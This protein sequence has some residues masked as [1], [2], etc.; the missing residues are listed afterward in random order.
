MNFYSLDNTS[1]CQP[2]VLSNAQNMI[3]LSYHGETTVN[4]VQWFMYSTE[5]TLAEFDDPMTLPM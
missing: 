1:G 5:M 4:G 2:E 3:T